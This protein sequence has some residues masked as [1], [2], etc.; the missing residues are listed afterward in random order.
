LREK[1]KNIKHL[2][3]TEQKNKFKTT[4]KNIINKKTK[5]NLLVFYYVFARYFHKENPKQNLA[6][7]RPYV[8]KPPHTSSQTPPRK[9]SHPDLIPL[10][11]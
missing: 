7:L 4:T 8:L 11:V 5:T 10:C 2:K 6:F 9:P 3:K 1:T